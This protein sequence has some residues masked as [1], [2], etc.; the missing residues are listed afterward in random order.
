MTGIYDTVPKRRAQ[1][2]NQMKVSQFDQWFLTKP[3]PTDLVRVFNVKY[4]VKKILC[5]SLVNKNSVKKAQTSPSKKRYFFGTN[6]GFLFN[7]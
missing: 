7:F 4:S 3:I 2:K 6:Q 1:A 5:G